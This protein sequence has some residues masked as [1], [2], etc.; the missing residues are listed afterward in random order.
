MAVIILNNSYISIVCLLLYSTLLD[1][2]VVVSS[3]LRVLLVVVDNRPLNSNWEK[4]NYNTL[5]S[6]INKK[7]ADAHSYDFL[8]VY[9]EIQNPIEHEYVLNNTDPPKIVRLNENMIQFFKE[10]ALPPDSLPEGYSHADSKSRAVA[11]SVKFKTFRASAWARILALW[12][13]LQSKYVKSRYD[14]LWYMD[15]DV[16]FSTAKDKWAQS[17]DD[18]FAQKDLVEY[19]PDPATSASILV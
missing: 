14:Y 18:F 11:F 6:F 5:S 12:H 15:S 2:V 17:L 1:N 19:G 9:P 3:K 4:A 7:Y 16:V 8:Y 10:Y 13:I